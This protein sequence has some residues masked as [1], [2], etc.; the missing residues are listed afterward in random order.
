MEDTF[1]REDEETDEE[2][3]E[4]IL[5]ENPFHD[6]RVQVLMNCLVSEVAGDVL[7][8]D[9]MEALAEEIKAVV[10]RYELVVDAVEEVAN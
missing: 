4:R 9:Q 2:F 7:S 5:S 10:D 1:Q 6:D 3:I 8:D